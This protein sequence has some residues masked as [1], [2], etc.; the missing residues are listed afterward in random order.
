MVLFVK[1]KKNLPPYPHPNSEDVLRNLGL[2]PFLSKN[3]EWLL[4]QWICPF[5]SP[6]L[7]PDRLGGLPGFSVDHYLVLLLHFIFIHK[8]LDN[9][10]RD[11]TAVLACMVDN[12]QWKTT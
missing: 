2:P 7:D 1:K 12:L 3:L 4:I 11:P 9:P 6:Y 10:N 5:I 8:R